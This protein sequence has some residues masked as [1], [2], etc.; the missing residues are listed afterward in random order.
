M[1][2]HLRLRLCVSLVTWFVR[3]GYY[4]V[5]NIPVSREPDM[6][7]L[8]TIYIPVSYPHKP[9]NEFL[10]DFVVRWLHNK[11]RVSRHLDGFVMRVQ[12][13]MWRHLIQ[14]TFLILFWRCA[15]LY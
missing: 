14:Y 7:F 2:K 9:C 4:V 13:M 8:L 11:P 12:Q 5:R 15:E 10:K 6:D 3:V 1:Y